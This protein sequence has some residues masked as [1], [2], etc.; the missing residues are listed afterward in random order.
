MSNV[1]KKGNGYFIEKCG[2]NGGKI[3]RVCLLQGHILVDIRSEFNG[4]KPS[5]VTVTNKVPVNI[6]DLPMSALLPY[7]DVPL[8]ML[9]KKFTEER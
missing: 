4:V 7:L 9:N 2:G 6:L 3:L 8:S 1:V 5:D